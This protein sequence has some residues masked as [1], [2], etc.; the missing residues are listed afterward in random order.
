VE[1]TNKNLISEKREARKKEFW[2]RRR[3]YSM[4]RKQNEETY[5][6][7]LLGVPLV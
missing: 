2:K 3:N 1:S 5:S 6:N 7:R 4:K